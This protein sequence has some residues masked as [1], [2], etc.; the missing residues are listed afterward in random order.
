M[1]LH[2]FSEKPLALYIFTKRNNIYTDFLNRTSSGSLVQNDV[3][4]QV[5]SIQIFFFEIHSNYFFKRN[6]YHL[7][8][9]VKAVLVP[10]MVNTQWIHSVIKELF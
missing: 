3:L 9:S 10:I 2:L 8:V 6:A 5:T 7:V 4:M 1:W